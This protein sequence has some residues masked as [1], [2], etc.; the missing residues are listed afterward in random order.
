MTLQNTLQSRY[1]AK[2]YDVN[3]S[4]PPDIVAK[5]LQSLQLSPSSLN[6]QPWHFIVADDEK[7]K[8]RIARSTSNMYQFNHGK[9]IEASHSIV[10]CARNNLSEDYFQSLLDQEKKDGR[11]P[12]EEAVNRAKQGRQAFLSLHEKE[13]DIAVWNQKQVYLALGFLLLSAGLLGVDATPI[14]GFDVDIL[15]Q[16]FD[17]KAKGLTPCVIV[18]LGYHAEGDFNA[19]LPKSRLPQDII[20][21]RA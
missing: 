3:K 8:K 5:L 13:H 4:L 19:K 1:S 17:L 21:S 14:E 6:N 10:L 16:E 20:F 2:S 9:I 11:L 15:S 18:T 7:G 12:N